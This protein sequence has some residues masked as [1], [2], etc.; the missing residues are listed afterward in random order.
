MAS[1]ARLPAPFRTK[2]ADRIVREIGEGEQLNRAV[3]VVGLTALGLGAVVGTGIFAILGKAVGDSGPAI[4]VSFVLAGITCLFSALSYAEMAAAVPVSGSAYTYS[5]AT[6]GELIA[7]IIGWDLILEYGFSVAVVAVAFGGYLKGLLDSVLGT[8]LPDSITQPPGE[9]GTFNLFAVLLVLGVTF[10][11]A[12]GVRESVRFNTGMVFV[13]VGI[14]LLFIVLA[15]TAFHSGNFDP[16]QPKGF[17]GTANAASLIFFAYIGFDAIST[18]SEEVKDPGKALPK[19]IIGSL[20]IA[21]AL[22]VLVAVAAIGAFNYKKLVGDDQPLATILRDGVGTSVGADLVSLGA[23]IAITSVVLTILYGRS[24]IMFSMCRDGLLPRG[25]A[26][27]SKRKT[28]VRI[29]LTFGI[30]AAAMAAFIPL[31]ELAELVNIGTLFAFFLVNVGV[32][33]LRRTKPDLDRPFRVPL[34][35]VFPL[36]GAAVRPPHDEAPGRDLGAVR[37]LVPARARR[38]LPLRPSALAAPARRAAPRGRH[39]PV[40]GLSQPELQ[41]FSAPD[42]YGDSGRLPSAP[43]TSRRWSGALTVPSQ[44]GGRIARTLMTASRAGFGP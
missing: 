29:T 24:R 14:L 10:V 31:S 16:F 5:Y 20:L 30:L 18:S 17:S 27:L 41:V 2:S 12:V 13:K 1:A 34:V 23:C 22:Y 4:V 36:I 40:G 9:G 38:L 37:D 25:F 43:S 28:P 3:G 6:L 26:K 7:W 39:G 19:G 35:P 15:F 32:I 42:P 8:S 33:I 21:T 44:P 11:L